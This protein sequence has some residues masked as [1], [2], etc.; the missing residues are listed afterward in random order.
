MFTTFVFSKS[1][2]FPPRCTRHFSHSGRILTC[3]VSG[4]GL[5]TVDNAAIVVSARATSLS[6]SARDRICP[7]LLG[8]HPATARRLNRALLSCRCRHLTT[9]K[10]EVA[11]GSDTN[12]SYPGNRENTATT[13]TSLRY[14]M[15]IEYWIWSPAL[16]LDLVL[17]PAVIYQKYNL[18]TSLK[19]Q[20]F[21]TKFDSD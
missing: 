5:L 1:L 16:W 12:G 20:S 6:R 8:S 7:E 14:Y 13:H 15:M 2:L 19:D 9:D 21:C 18:T 3:R 17:R 10:H 4:V 11:P